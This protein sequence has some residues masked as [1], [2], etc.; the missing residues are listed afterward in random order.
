MFGR[1]SFAAKA[2]CF[3]PSAKQYVL[4]CARAVHTCRAHILKYSF[5]RAAPIGNA[6]TLESQACRNQPGK[7][8]KVLVLLRTQ[9]KAKQSTA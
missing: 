9:R 2:A 5:L 6:E 3:S 4:R 8:E 1:L 7:R